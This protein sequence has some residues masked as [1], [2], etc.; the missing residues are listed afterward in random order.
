MR[1]VSRFCHCWVRP[2][3]SQSLYSNLKSLNQLSN[4]SLED[5]H[6][7][8][9]CAANGSNL[10]WS[11][12]EKEVKQEIETEIEKKQEIEEVEE[13]NESEKKNS[14]ESISADSVRNT[15]YV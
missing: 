5:I 7:A 4:Y 11:S 12:K 6:S 9:L 14:D 8:L 15:D 10:D 1:M 13:I 3:L 2:T